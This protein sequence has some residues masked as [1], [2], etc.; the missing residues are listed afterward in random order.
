MRRITGAVYARGR[1][2]KKLSKRVILG[3]LRNSFP[4][5]MR[6]RI[7]R[8]AQRGSFRSR[9]F[10]PVEFLRD[11]ARNDPNGFHRFLWAHHLAYAESY[12]IARFAPENLDASRHMLFADIEEHLRERALTP[13]R[14]VWSVFEAGCSL[15]YLL[16]HAET[17][18]FPSATRLIGVDV[19]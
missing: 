3:L 11:L 4:L 8:W 18:V 1:A 15:G 9:L 2:A 5:A 17:K 6:K 10:S 14:D 16:R 13:E 19:D 12:E 7:L